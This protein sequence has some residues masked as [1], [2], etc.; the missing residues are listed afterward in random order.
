MSL[1]KKYL[2]SKPVCKVTF[3]ILKDE[4]NAADTVALAGDFN[5]WKETPM[6]KLKSGDFSLTLDLETDN[7]YQF[8]YHLDNETWE[9][10]W[11]AD[12]YVPSPICYE[13][14]SVVIV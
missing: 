7:K 13:D 5:D 10:D 14:N 12:E 2:K 1:N 8:K 6:K 11:N 4:C 3:K 9:N